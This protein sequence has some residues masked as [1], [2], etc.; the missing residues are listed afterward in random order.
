MVAGSRGV[1]QI[2][3]Y[4]QSVLPKRLADSRGSIAVAPYSINNR[5]CPDPVNRANGCLHRKHP[6]D[7]VTD[8]VVV[9]PTAHLTRDLIGIARVRRQLRR[10]SKCHELV[11][12][13]ELPRDLYVCRAPGRKWDLS[14]RT[15]SRPYVP[16]REIAVP[17][18]AAT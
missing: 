4:E 13:R 9:Q 8:G 1:L 18:I 7:T 16:T 12:T 17:F 10:A 3:V 11:P 14:T 15:I 2:R 6:V 5:Q